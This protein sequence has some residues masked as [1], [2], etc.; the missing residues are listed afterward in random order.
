MLYMFLLVVA[1]TRVQS[2]YKIFYINNII[3]SMLYMMII[4]SY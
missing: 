4:I 1:L 3:N 2:G